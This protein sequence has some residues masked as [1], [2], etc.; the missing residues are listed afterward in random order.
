MYVLKI[1]LT[2]MEKRNAKSLWSALIFLI[3]KRGRESDEKKIK[4]F[5]FIGVFVYFEKT[6]FW[7][8][9]FVSLVIQIILM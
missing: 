2:E 5:L 3:K 6:L 8:L 1:F 7:N 4:A 9:A